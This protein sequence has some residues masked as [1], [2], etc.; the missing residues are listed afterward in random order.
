MGNI[1]LGRIKCRFNEDRKSQH[2]LWRSA[3]SPFMT[4]EFY[5]MKTSL[6]YFLVVISQLN[7][8]AQL[9][10]V[11]AIG[12]EGTNID[13]PSIKVYEDTS[14]EGPGFFYN[15]CAQGVNPVKASS[16]LAAQGGKS[17]GIENLSDANPMTAWVEG[18]KGY[19]IGEWFE[20]E[21][22]RVNS[23]YNGYQSTPL[24]W[25][26]N[27]RVKR[28]KVYVDGKP[29]CFLDLTD[30]MGEQRF[31]LNLEWKDPEHPYRFRFEIADVYKGDKWDD[32]CISHIDD[33]ACCFAANTQ[34]SS[35]AGSVVE[36][37]ALQQ[38][39]EILTYDFA[40]DTVHASAV[41]L[42][43]HQ[44]HA[45]MLRVTAGGK[46]IDITS[47]HPLFIKGQGFISMNALRAQ[48]PQGTYEDIAGRFEVMMWDTA[49]QSSQFVTITSIAVLTGDFQTVTVRSLSSGTSYIV[50]GF[51]TKTY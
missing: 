11:T 13:W 30:E 23:I 12:G 35:W 7:L 17:Y 20:V 37:D 31:E 6:I 48:T 4:L 22:S 9:P 45:S 47:D 18:A 29:F 2:S 14:S 46:Q 15:D 39:T 49:T 28:F 10:V 44:L 36:A 50:N 1:S 51:I 16:T 42:V 19:G 41:Q 33:I 38:G 8:S 32:V 3:G 34:L 24:N 27:S 40:G 26:N 5:P 43:A 25:R 21:G